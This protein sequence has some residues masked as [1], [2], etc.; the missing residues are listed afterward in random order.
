MVLKGTQENRYSIG[1]PLRRRA[2]YLLAK[3]P[4]LGSGAAQALAVKAAIEHLGS[5]GAS[6]DVAKGGK[7][8]GKW[9]LDPF[10]AKISCWVEYRKGMQ[11]TCKSVR[12]HKQR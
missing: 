3:D 7:P 6:G 9:W 1:G 4:R 2:A 10:V 8:P 12:S 11:Q 5:K